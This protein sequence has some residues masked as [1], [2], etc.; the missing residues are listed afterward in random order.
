MLAR[1]WKSAVVEGMLNGAAMEFS[2]PEGLA[3]E[4]GLTQ[5]GY[6]L[7]DIQAQEILQLRLQRLTGLEQEKLLMN[8]KRL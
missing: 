3:K 6:K 8:I 2:R 7:S 5:S 1:T 4:F